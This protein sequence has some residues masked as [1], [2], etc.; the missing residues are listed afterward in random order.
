MGVRVLGT[1]IDIDV[2]GQAGVT[3]E[4]C[5]AARHVR[6]GAEVDG[7]PEMW[8]MEGDMAPMAADMRDGDF[9]GELAGVAVFRSGLGVDA[10]LEYA[11]KELDGEGV[12]GGHA[13]DV[14]KANGERHGGGGGEEG[15]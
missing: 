12:D 6:P 15:G 10:E 8:G 7:G 4:V 5:L 13:V 9:E 1:G 14:G 11:G 2:E 3:G